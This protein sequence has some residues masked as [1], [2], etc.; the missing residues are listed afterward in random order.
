MS[1][2][3]KK[4]LKNLIVNLNLDNKIE[5][6]DY[7]DMDSKKIILSFDLILS[8]TKKYEGFGLSIAEAMSVGT[9]ILATNVGGVKEFF[10]SN[11]GQLIR[12]GGIEEIKNSLMNFC[13]YKKDWDDKAKTAKVRIEKYFN[14]EIMGD[15][16]MK[17][18]SL[19][20]TE[21]K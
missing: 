11:C 20:L 1:E 21:A 19:K 3:K 15:N 7:V 6:L 18:L 8:L 16:Y 17:H 13:D 5:F 14:A 12:P 10:N 2:V 4:K 9:P